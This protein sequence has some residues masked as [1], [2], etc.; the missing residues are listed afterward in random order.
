MKIEEK[1]F[2]KKRVV[3]YQSENKNAPII[4]SNDY[5]ECGETLIEKCKEMNIPDFNLVTISHL[6]WD[7]EMS[8]WPHEPVVAAND[9]FTGKADEYMELLKKEII[10]YAESVIG[11]FNGKRI[12]SGYSMAGLFA[13]YAPFI[14]DFLMHLSVC[15][16]RSD[17][18]IS[19][20]I[21]VN[22]ILR[23]KLML[24]IFQ[25]EIKKLR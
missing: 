11:S 6:S 22:M 21:S 9:H 24:C 14:T 17:I 2:G 25:S 23:K 4:Y 8:P 16:H 19:G 15:Q 20:I 18:R 12:L 13:A 7:Q 1:N 3:V 10:P 5:S